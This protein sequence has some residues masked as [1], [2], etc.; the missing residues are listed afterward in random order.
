MWAQGLLAPCNA[1]NRS[2]AGMAISAS[3]KYDFWC[4]TGVLE[5]VTRFFYSADFIPLARLDDTRRPI[6]LL[7]GLLRER[8]WK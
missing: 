1:I 5:R 2:A 3:A 8:G 4:S 7:W 6:L